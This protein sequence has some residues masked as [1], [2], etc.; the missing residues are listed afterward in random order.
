MEEKG[1]KRKGGRERWEMK[2]ERPASIFCPQGPQ[3]SY[4]ATD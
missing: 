3:S 4:Y 2:R 1:G